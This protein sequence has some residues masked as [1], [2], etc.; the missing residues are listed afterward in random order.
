[1]GKDSFWHVLVR[2]TPEVMAAVEAGAICNTY[3]LLCFIA[4]NYATAEAK[5]SV[6]RD[7][8]VN[9]TILKVYTNK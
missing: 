9:I 1:M 6:G 2:R 3:E 4:E 8:L 7:C 5:K